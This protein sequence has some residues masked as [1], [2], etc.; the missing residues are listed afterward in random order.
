MPE[1]RQRAAD[2]TGQPG[3]STRRSMHPRRAADAK[4]GTFERFDLP[5]IHVHGLEEVSPASD[6]CPRPG[7]RGGGGLVVAE[8]GGHRLLPRRRAVGPGR[9][10]G[11]RRF[12]R[13]RGPGGAGRGPGGPGRRSRWACRGPCRSSTM[14]GRRLV[15]LRQ[16]VMLRPEVSGR[17]AKVA[18]QNGQR[19]R[20]GQLLVQLDDTCSAPS[21]SRPRRRRHRPHQPA[22]QPRA[23]GAELRQPERG[24][25]ERRRTAGGR[26]PGGAGPGPADAHAGAAPFDATAGIRVGQRRRLREGRRRHRQRRGH[27]VDVRSTSACPSATCRA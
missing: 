18:F 5:R 25:P 10:A 26:G 6:R 12:R 27:V 4:P 14:P 3:V 21:C 24:R 2:A 8:Q 23:G 11:V 16:G 20:R 19:V 15:A 1:T 9:C 13:R 17:I 7:R 22:A